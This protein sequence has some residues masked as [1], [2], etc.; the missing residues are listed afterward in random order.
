[1]LKNDGI[2]LVSMRASISQ[3]FFGSCPCYLADD[4][5]L[6]DGHHLRLIGNHHTA[7]ALVYYLTKVGASLPGSMLNRNQTWLPPEP[8]DKNPIAETIC[9]RGKAFRKFALLGEGWAWNNKDPQK[10]GYESCIGNS[11]LELPFAVT[12]TNKV[13]RITI[14]LGYVR[15]SHHVREATIFCRGVCTCG[16]EALMNYHRENSTQ[17]HFSNFELSIGSA[18]STQPVTCTLVIESSTEGMTEDS[19]VKVTS[20]ATEEGSCTPGHP[21]TAFTEFGA[22]GYVV[23]PHK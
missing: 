12:T 20:F 23:T 8:F 11:S 7:R 10:T 22:F 3:A 17:T 13:T 16:R 14:S 1:M 6:D 15:S 2:P 4:M 5:Y 9:H 21:H 18:E 19:C